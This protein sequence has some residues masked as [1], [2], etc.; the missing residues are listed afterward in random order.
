MFKAWADHAEH[1]ERQQGKLVDAIQPVPLWKSLG[2]ANVPT[3]ATTTQLMVLGGP[4]SGRMWFIHRVGILGGD[5]HTAVAGAVVE[6]Y[7]GPGQE[8]DATALLYT[9]LSVPS[10]IV[11]GR[12][13]NPVQYGERLYALIYN[14]PANQQFQFVAGIE[15]YPALSTTS[16]KIVS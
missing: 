11:E 6:I 9:G 8:A 13:H 10:L 16:M 2:V 3:A 7:A 1:I 12:N 14:P 15:D 5:N 4:A